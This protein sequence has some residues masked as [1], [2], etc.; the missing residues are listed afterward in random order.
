MADPSP[1][2]NF[3][4]LA[5]HVIG[6][7]KSELMQI[8]DVALYEARR[9]EPPHP[10][11]L[12]RHGRKVFSQ[13]DED[14]IT[15]EI[16]R[17]L[18]LTKGVFAEF[19]VGDGLENNTLALAAAGWKGFWVGGQDLRVNPNPSNLAKPN[20]DFIKAWVK[21]DNAHALCEQG[22]TRIAQEAVDLL[23]IDLDGNDYYIAEAL[24]ARGVAPKVVIVEYNAKFIPPIE[25]KIEYSDDH[26]W[27]GDDYFGA[28]LASFCRLFE[29]HG[30]FLACCNAFTGA[31]AFFVHAAYRDKFKDIPQDIAQLW[32][33]PRYALPYRYGHPGS[34][35]TVD[36]IFKALNK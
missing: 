30:Y 29:K 26:A 2:P 12:N 34:P 4:Q 13:T 6:H 36:L 3:W 8:R 19:G 9:S 15:F 17:R 7:L 1:P 22:L 33:E 32:S 20:F 35:K 18:G 24:L 16:V 27:Q 14:G 5:N 25:W 21:Q 28:S 31:N 23:S 11:P 10:N